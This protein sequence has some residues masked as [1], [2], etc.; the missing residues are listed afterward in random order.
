MQRKNLLFP[1]SGSPSKPF[2]RGGMSRGRGNI[3]QNPGRPNGPMQITPNHQPGMMQ[4]GSK[5]F[6]DMDTDCHYWFKPNTDK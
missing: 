4:P 3:Q 1:G 5:F 2:Y 6:L